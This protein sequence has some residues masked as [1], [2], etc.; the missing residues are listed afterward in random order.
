[1]FAFNDAVP[2]TFFWRNIIDRVFCSISLRIV[3]AIMNAAVVRPS[4]CIFCSFRSCAE[5]STSTAFQT[6]S[7]PKHRDSRQ[8]NREKPHGKK[9]KDDNFQYGS[10]RDMQREE[11]FR[12][13]RTEL[14]RS[15]GDSGSY[16]RLRPSNLHASTKG[17]P[18]TPGKANAE[19]I[20]LPSE[21]VLVFIKPKPMDL[22]TFTFDDFKLRLFN[23]PILA[24][25]RLPRKELAEKYD[26]YVE[27]MKRRIR[28]DDGAKDFMLDRLRAAVGTRMPKSKTNSFLVDVEV[29]ASFF[30]HMNKDTL[31]STTLKKQAQLVNFQSPSEWWP[32]ARHVQRAIHLHVGPTNSGKTYHALKRLESAQSGIYA[33]PLRLLAHEVFMRLNAA[34]KVCNLLT[35]DDRRYGDATNKEA[36]GMTSC[37]VEMIPTRTDLDVAVIDEIQMIAHPERGWAWTQALMGV[38]AKEVHLCGEARAVPIIKELMAAVGDKVT[39]HEYERLSPLEMA[40]KSLEGNLSRLKKGDC[41]VAFNI[42][43]IHGLRRTVEERT[44]KK[45]AIVYGSLP[46]ETRAQQARLFNDPNNDYDYLVASNAVGMGLNLSIR[47]IIFH[48]SVHFNGTDKFIPVEDSE[49]KQIGGRAGRY[50]TSFDDVAKGKAVDVDDGAVDNVL[51][52]VQPPKPRVPGQVTTLEAMDYRNIANGMSAELQPIT[53]VGVLPPDITLERFARYFPPHTPTSYIL[54]R[55]FEL[56]RTSSSYFLCDLKQ[57]V[58]VADAIEEVDGLTW[59]ERLIFLQAPIAPDKPQDRN[60]AREL[61][62]VVADKRAVSILDL[63][64]LD[65][66]L[67][68]AEQD[69]RRYLKDLESLHSGVVLLMWLSY[70]LVHNF[71]HVGLSRHVKELVETRIAEVL[72]KQ[73]V[74]YDHERAIRSREK[75]IKDLLTS[76]GRNAA[77]I[78]SNMHGFEAPADPA[79]ELASLVEPDA[80]EMETSSAE[81]AG[82][83][84]GPLLDTRG[85]QEAI[86]LQ[87]TPER[88]PEAPAQA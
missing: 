79:H 5:F 87:D 71:V 2:G 50:S 66:D 30:A 59:A 83:T 19:F 73:S 60:L 80:S 58:G 70:R 9:R 37:T 27:D 48:S 75:A 14:R 69:D 1:M 88:Q 18:A 54:I 17:K 78:K 45:C 44:G 24:R 16:F 72:E 56:S 39:V 65:L 36:A 63:E 82:H 23:D 28:K 76:A 57:A 40:P 61:A 81:G 42:L 13:K 12:P 15:E 34:G 41:I 22:L 68:K 4:R 43:T 84:D 25:L 7:R 51:T 35:G 31:D 49:I 8:G 77:D 38:R 33:G 3:R 11:S 62:Q 55:M 85:S 32:G 52:N 67:L 53:K 47:R 29:R 20:N 6:P 74:N 10:A 64:S 26:E 86:D 46:P 21:R